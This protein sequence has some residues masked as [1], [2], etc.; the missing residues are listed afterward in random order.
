MQPHGRHQSEPAEVARPRIAVS[1]SRHREQ[2]GAGHE[3]L[4]RNHLGRQDR[5]EGVGTDAEACEE[6]LERSQVAV[7]TIDPSH[8]IAAKPDGVHLGD[9]REEIEH[10]H[11]RAQQGVPAARDAARSRHGAI[12]LGKEDQAE[13][14]QRDEIVVLVGVELT[15]HPA[16]AEQA[17]QRDRSPSADAGQRHH[18][19]HDARQQQQADVRSGGRQRLDRVQPGEVGNVEAG[20]A[21]REATPGHDEAGTEGQQQQENGRK[22]PQSRNRHIRIEVSMP[23]THG[24]TPSTRI[25]ALPQSITA[26]IGATIVPSASLQKRT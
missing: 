21:I 17:A 8:R 4:E 7:D 15:L 10:G 25:S 3:E 6:F 19:G 26:R 22:Q 24:N 1:S 13:K 23:C 18:D 12:D 16:V 2:V 14:D 20:L 9:G 5:P 11:G